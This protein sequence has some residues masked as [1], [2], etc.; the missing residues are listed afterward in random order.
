MQLDDADLDELSDK[1]WKRFLSPK[2]VVLTTVQDNAVIK[3]KGNSLI[4]YD[5]DNSLT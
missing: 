4:V 3:V 1:Y 5:G 2:P